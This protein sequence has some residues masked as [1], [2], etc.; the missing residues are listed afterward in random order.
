MY[1][2]N[3][4]PHI[5][6]KTGVGSALVDGKK[7][8]LSYPPIKRENDP[9]IP[10]EILGDIK[11]KGTVNE[12]G[13]EYVA[14]SD[15]IGAETFYDTM[16]LIIIDDSKDI[17]GINRA[18]D[19]AFMLTLMNEF[20]FDIER[21]KMNIASY[22]PA[23]AEE[24]A[25]W[26]RIG[27][28]IL[29]RLKANGAKHPCLHTTAERLAELRR[30]YEGEDSLIKRNIA[31]MVAKAENLS[32]DEKYALRED[33][34][35]F[36]T[37]IK[38]PHNTLD[39]YDEGGRLGEVNQYAWNS[40]IFAFGYHMTGNE[41]YARQAYYICTDLAAWTHWCPGH[42]LNCAGACSDMATAYDWLYNVWN[43]MKLDTGAVKRGIF[44]LGIHEAWLSVVADE[45]MY[46]TDVLIGWRFKNKS[47]N[48]NSVCNGN[49]LI[50]CLS[51]LVDGVDNVVCHRNFAKLVELTGETMSG[52][53]QDGLVL[54]QY[55]P[56]GSYIESNSYWSFGTNN[57]FKA[58]GALKTV[59][60]TDLG[61]HH[62]AGMDQ[63]CYYAVNSES[64]DYVGWNYHDGSLAPQDTSMFNTFAYVSGDY[65]LFAMRRDQLER[66]KT[67]SLY[68]ILYSPQLLGI[69]VP[70]TE[71]LPLDDYMEGIDALTVRNG[72]ASGSLYAAMIGGV[73]PTGGSHNQLDSGAFVYHN[74]KVNWFMDLGADNY[75]VKG[76]YFDNNALYRRNAEGNNCLAVKSFTYGQ[77]TGGRGEVIEQ[78]AGKSSPYIMIDN[79]SVY[80]DVAKEARRGMLLT[81]N[82]S[83][84]IIKD[85]VI[86]AEP[87]TAWWT[88]NFN[89]ADITA[90][91]STDG[92]HV[93]MTHKDGASIMVTL[94]GGERFEITDSY[95]FLLDGTRSFEGEHD[96]KDIS[97]LVVAFHDV[98]KINCAVT[99]ERTTASS[100][101]DPL[102]PM[103]Q[104][105]Q[106]NA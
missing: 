19:T 106:L 7:E 76:G 74:D 83:T 103:S 17:H 61:F 3:K 95:T 37:P 14:L 49:I 45:C 69:E 80:K 70:K 30:L 34:C 54:K 5:C 68:D 39:G 47:D 63:T 94:H 67:V 24:R 91:I 15:I 86:F 96:R 32:K 25:G 8:A 85:E 100:S 36:V 88:A 2:Y 51:L 20:I 50:A 77:F 73:N 101:F 23:T 10:A 60:G 84:V 33:G 38:N 27:E 79:T 11:H 16:G 59:I 65:D 41:L 13:K 43:Q 48:W 99:I 44:N 1:D 102:T 42:F 46:P 75:N 35:G 28:D 9:L 93:T 105:K 64:A 92:K 6:L 66:G 78:A 4:R 57:L 104:W 58:M 52:L 56:D 29:S 62:A 26:K 55:A 97:R 89:S 98:T 82:R 90:T 21:V 31:T 81:D 72:W 18:D 53:L 22:A 87:T 71:S 40:L 12:G